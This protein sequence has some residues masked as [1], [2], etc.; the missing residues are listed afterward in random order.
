MNHSALRAQNYRLRVQRAPSAR[1][2]SEG[3]QRESFNGQT[4]DVPAAHLLE[5]NRRPHHRLSLASKISSTLSEAQTP[6]ELYDHLARS[7]FDLLP[8]IHLVTLFQAEAESRALAC[9]YAAREIRLRPERLDPA[10]QPCPVG[11]E[12]PLTALRLHRPVVI[13]DLL[14]YQVENDPAH[15]TSLYQSLLATPMTRRGE[16]EGVLEVFSRARRRFGPFEMDLLALLANTTAIALEALRLG[17]DLSESNSQLTQTYDAAVEGWRRALELRDQATEGHGCRV[18]ELTVRLAMRLGYTSP[19]LTQLRFGAQLHDIGKIGVPDSVLLKPGP[20]DDDDTR[21]MR[22]HPVYAYEMLSP[23]PNFQSILDIPFYHHERWD[24]SGY[25]R[26]LQGEQIPRPARI[27]A[28]IDVWDA[29]C[30]DRPYRPAWPEEKAVRYI[31]E[32]SGKH[33]DPAIVAEFLEMVV[34]EELDAVAY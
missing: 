34:A 25:P 4:H 32:Q 29:L 13:H 27:F 21:I 9:T 17:R 19:E 16:V 6:S 28:V 30:S 15:P 20:L 3:C 12:I 26:G 31:R 22:K 2:S 10:A 8:R 7:I 33:F 1:F 18:A 5:R 24:G 23:V 14:H 11:L